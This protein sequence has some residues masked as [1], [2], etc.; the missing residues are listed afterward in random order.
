MQKSGVK[1]IEQVE[2]ERLSNLGKLTLLIKEQLLDD[3]DHDVNRPQVRQA[4]NDY[5]GEI[6][7]KLTFLLHFKVEERISEM[8][9]RAFPVKVGNQDDVYLPL[10]LNRVGEAKE[11]YRIEFS[12]FPRDLIQERSKKKCGSRFEVYASLCTSCWR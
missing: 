10:L 1:R 2:L 12:V 6:N 8:L 5:L 11:K 7:T 3:L 4:P 9:L